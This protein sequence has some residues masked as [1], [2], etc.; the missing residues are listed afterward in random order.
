[1]GYFKGVTRGVFSVTKANGTKDTVVLEFTFTKR[2][3]A[4]HVCMYPHCESNITTKSLRRYI[5]FTIGVQRNA[6]DKI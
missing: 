5:S 4:K 6:L 2:V 1:M 3:A